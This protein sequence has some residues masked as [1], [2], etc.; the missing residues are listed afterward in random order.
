MRGNV[1]SHA[2]AK[3]HLCNCNPPIS[4]YVARPVTPKSVPPKIGPARLILAK[5]SA[6]TGPPRPLVPSCQNQSPWGTNFGKKLSAKIDPPSKWHSYSCVYM[7]TWMQ[8]LY[9]AMHGYL[10]SLHPII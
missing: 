10:A 7:A 5:I 4:F 3:K 1:I 6:K 9:L 2:C 8:L